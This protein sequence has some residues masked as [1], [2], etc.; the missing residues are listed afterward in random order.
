MS[1]FAKNNAT[2]FSFDL[3][4]YEPSVMV[5]FSI[6]HGGV[7][8]A[9]LAI[10]GEPLLD[11]SDSNENPRQ[12]VDIAVKMSRLHLVQMLLHA[13]AQVSVLD[14]PLVRKT[15]D[16]MDDP[17]MVY[18]QRAVDPCS[19]D[20]T[21]EGFCDRCLRPAVSKPDRKD[22]VHLGSSC[23]PDTKGKFVAGQPCGKG[24]GD[25]DGE[26]VCRLPQNTHRECE[27]TFIP[28]DTAALAEALNLIEKM[29]FT[30]T[31]SRT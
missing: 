30:V 25:E 3:M 1:A 22:W 29:G 13:L 9:N 6:A 19:G 16:Q 26:W 2:A 15:V 12:N 27:V 20:Y 18:L 17:F 28:R 14:Y 21:I 11:G 5:D 10:E 8:V 7:G 24:H 31:S 4:R 23:G